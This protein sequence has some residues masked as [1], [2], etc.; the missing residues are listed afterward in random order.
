MPIDPLRLGP[1]ASSE[2]H[3]RRRTQ[4]QPTEQSASATL[5]FPLTDAGTAD[6]DIQP[7]LSPELATLVEKLDAA[8][9][10]LEAE[11]TG[12]RLDDYRRAVGRFLDASLKQSD[13]MSRETSLGLSQRVF[14]CITR[15]NILISD[16]TDAVLGRQR[17]NAQVRRLILQIKGLLIDLYR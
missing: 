17:D 6:D 1:L 14:A 16:L 5:P 2:R 4:G 3:L 7:R 13:R 11:L 15:T 12:A 8:A 9:A 10:A